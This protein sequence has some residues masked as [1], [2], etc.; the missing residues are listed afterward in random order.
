MK[1][2]NAGLSATETFEAYAA[3]VRFR[4]LPL[5]LHS[6]S[7]VDIFSFRRV[8]VQMIAAEAVFLEKGKIFRVIGLAPPA[9][10]LSSR[11]G[12]IWR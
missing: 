11:W 8:A 12:G 6:M 4:S 3:N 10:S 2:R 9:P 1:D 5:L 7:A